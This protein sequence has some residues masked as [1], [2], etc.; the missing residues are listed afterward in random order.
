[1]THKAYPVSVMDG[2]HRKGADP[3][4]TESDEVN[5]IDL[6]MDDPDLDTYHQRV[7]SSGTSAQKYEKGKS[8][9]ILE[10]IRR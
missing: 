1:M 9:D 7:E 10:S 2:S 6:T 8:R 5:V 3:S 4:W